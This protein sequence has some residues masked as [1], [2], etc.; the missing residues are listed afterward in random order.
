[1]KVVGIAISGFVGICFLAL[2][3]LALMQL[4]S[5][6]FP[7]KPHS[8]ER[9]G[10]FVTAPAFTALTVFGLGGFGCVWKAV[11]LW[12]ERLRDKA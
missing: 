11:A 9:Y 10:L 12:R 6:S 5:G 3:A 2:A 8:S 7:I 4:V 1:M